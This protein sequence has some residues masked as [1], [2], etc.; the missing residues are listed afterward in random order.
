[1]LINEITMHSNV[2]YDPK[3]QITIK[4]PI[5]TFS[6]NE[7]ENFYHEFFGLTK[8][9]PNSQRRNDFVAFT[10]AILEKVKQK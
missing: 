6:D 4:N 2:A 1:M 7:I 10:K 5:K 8:T 9:Y 3:I